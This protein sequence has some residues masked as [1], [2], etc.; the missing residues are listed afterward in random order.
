MYIYM[1]S[2][3]K[4]GNNKYFNAPPL[5]ADGR[6]FTDYRPQCTLNNQI[7]AQNNG[8][9]S[10]DYRMYLKLYLMNNRTLVEFQL[11]H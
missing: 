4:T 11:T 10:F 1:A 6:H 9:S 3:Y 5:M 7:R 8:L 2:C